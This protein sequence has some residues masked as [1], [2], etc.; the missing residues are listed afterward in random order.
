MIVL[1]HNYPVL[2]DDDVLH[3]LPERAYTLIISLPLHFCFAVNLRHAAGIADF[4]ISS[5]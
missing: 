4:Q 3:H 1:T 2:S 5:I